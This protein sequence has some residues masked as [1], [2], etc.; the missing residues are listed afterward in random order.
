[1]RLREMSLRV[2]TKSAVGVF[3]PSFLSKEERCEKWN[4]DVRNGI[5]TLA[6]VRQIYKR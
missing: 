5:K 3:R 4:E 2:G 1:M 6:G